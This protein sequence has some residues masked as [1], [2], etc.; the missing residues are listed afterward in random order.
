MKHTTKNLVL[1]V[2]I[3]AKIHNFSD[4]H[5]EN[6]RVYAKQI[7]FRQGCHMYHLEE[8]ELIA[9]K[10]PVYSL[11]FIF[12]IIIITI[13]I[14]KVLILLVANWISFFRD[15]GSINFLMKS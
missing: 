4:G 8:E 5:E 10:H 9:V 7:L 15:Q 14:I 2:A 12:I 1:I 6:V 11:I 3:P 13:L